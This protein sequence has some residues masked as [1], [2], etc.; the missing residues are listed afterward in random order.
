M[1]GTR[2]VLSVGHGTIASDGTLTLVQQ[3]RDEGEK[4]HERVWHIRQ[5]GPGKF[6]GSMSEA[7]GPVTIEQ[8]GEKYRFRFNLKGGLTAEQWL[9]PNADGSSGLSILT[10]RKFGMIVAKSEA[11]IRRLSQEANNSR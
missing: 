9:A 4:P 7:A 2:R 1:K 8:V 5:V 10:V 11:T 3:V 6:A